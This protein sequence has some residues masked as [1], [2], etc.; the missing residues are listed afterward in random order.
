M[1]SKAPIVESIASAV[2]EERLV[3][4]ALDLV[5]VASP[6][7]HEEAMAER[8]AKALRSLGLDVAR[9][10][11]EDGRPNVVGTLVGTGDGPD[12]KSVV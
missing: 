5:G 10:E 4:I 6:T 11:V 1:S 7:G 12:R 9:Q 2:S 8:M 3:Q